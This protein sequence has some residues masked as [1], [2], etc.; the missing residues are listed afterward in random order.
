[1]AIL[2]VRLALF[3]SKNRRAR[4]PIPGT[5]SAITR[6]DLLR[7]HRRFFQ[8]RNV[9]LVAVGDF[10]RAKFIGVVGKFLGGW[11][12]TADFEPPELPPFPERVERR[13][14]LVRAPFPQT[15][16]LAADFAPPHNSHLWI[17]SR[18]ANYILGGSGLSSILMEKLRTETGWAYFAGSV[19]IPDQKKGLFIAYTGTAPKRV[20]LVVGKMLDIFEKFA[21]K[22]AF[23]TEKRLKFA[24]E[25]LLN[26]FVFL[27]DSKAQIVYRKAILD[28]YGYPG[29]YLSSFKRRVQNISVRELK[30]QLPVFFYPNIFII[31]GQYPE[32]I[33]KVFGADYKFVENDISKVFRSLLSFSPSSRPAS[34]PV[35]KNK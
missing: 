1:M 34:R 16:I 26:K 19:L 5:I 22:K 23:I 28:Y 11:K 29:D 17:T 6:D 35:G 3:G 12:G 9:R 2:L 20:P 25:S 14:F 24:R 7:F 15:L 31:V 18:I 13:V 33:R 10:E 8:P 32:Q 27:F 21:K 30:A 4:I